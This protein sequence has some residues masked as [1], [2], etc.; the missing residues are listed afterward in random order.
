MEVTV[1]Q[2]VKLHNRVQSNAVLDSTAATHGLGEGWVPSGWERNSVRTIG[3][4]LS[5]REITPSKERTMRKLYGTVHTV[6]C[7]DGASLASNLS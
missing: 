4:L 6:H 3:S 1:L 7:T 2:R 5:K